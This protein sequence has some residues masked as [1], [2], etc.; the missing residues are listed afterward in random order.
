MVLDNLVAQ[1]DLEGGLRLAA[2]RAPVGRIGEPEEVAGAI[3]LLLGD[4]ASFVTGSMLTVDG[5]MT[6]G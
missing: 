2:G 5:G 4:G 1:G 3:A 6:A